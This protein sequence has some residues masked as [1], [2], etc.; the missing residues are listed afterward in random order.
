M[1]DLYVLNV[2]KPSGTCYASGSLQMGNEE[3]QSPKGTESR[4]PTHPNSKG[5]ADATS[6]A[7][8]EIYSQSRKQKSHQKRQQIGAVRAEQ[9][10]G[11]Q[12]KKHIKKRKRANLDAVDEEL[13]MDGKLEG[14]KPQEKGRGKK[15]KIEE[16][17]C[18]VDSAEGEGEEEEMSEG[19]GGGERE[20]EK[21][22]EKGKEKQRFI[23]FI[24]WSVLIQTSWYSRGS[25]EISN[26]PL[27]WTLL[28]R[29]SLHVVRRFFAPV[30]LSLILILIHRSTARSTTSY[31]ENVLK[32]ENHDQIKRL[33]LPRILEQNLTPTST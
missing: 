18:G 33:R 4:E 17:K 13:G 1:E 24:G 27:R 30:W 5:P 9:H 21:E 19:E 6:L 25:Q 29:I 16:T 8:Q 2:E 10:N 14:G 3:G 11:D 22:K 12:D 23:L 32:W 26:I 28:R 15:Q 20:K 31:S 7:Q